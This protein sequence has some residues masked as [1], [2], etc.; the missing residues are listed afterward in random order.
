MERGLGG[1]R[2][3]KNDEDSMFADRAIRV[4]FTSGSQDIFFNFSHFFPNF[5]P[6][7]PTFLNF[8]L[9]HFFPFFQKSIEMKANCTEGTF[10]KMRKNGS[11][12]N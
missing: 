11:A 10:E 8:W 7:F 2:V 9:T 3:K 1:I 4:K 12:L 5:S 6:S